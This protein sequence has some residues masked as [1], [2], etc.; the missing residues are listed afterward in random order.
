MKK[1][2]AVILLLAF[3]ALPA[4]AENKEAERASA[5][6]EEKAGGEYDVIV[7]PAIEALRDAWRAVYTEDGMADLYAGHSGYLEIKNTRIVQIREAPRKSFNETGEPDKAT[8]VFG[9]IACV[10]EFVLAHDYF[11]SEPY[12]LINGTSAAECVLVRRDGSLEP[13]RNPFVLYRAATYDMD[14]SGII[15]EIVDLNGEYNAVCHLLEE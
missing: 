8:E 13:A 14:F 15:E 3:L 6:A 1:C 11:G 12:Y 2:L 9:D 7:L 5:P 4:L 10:V